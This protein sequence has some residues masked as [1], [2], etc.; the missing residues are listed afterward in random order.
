MQ[1]VSI[2]CSETHFAFKSQHL[3][4]T[5]VK[6]YIVYKGENP[7]QIIVIAVDRIQYM[8]QGRLLHVAFFD[9]ASL[10]FFENP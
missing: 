9:S 2:A 8:V 5:W 6:L 7:I 4:E 1:F 10:P 3:P